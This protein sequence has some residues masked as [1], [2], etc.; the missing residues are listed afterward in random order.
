V[1]EVLAYSDFLVLD[2]RLTVSIQPAVPMLSGYALYWPFRP[3]DRHVIDITLGVLLSEP[4]EFDI[5][6]YVALPRWLAGTRTFRFSSGCVRTDLFGRTD[7]NFLRQLL[8]IQE[9]P[10]GQPA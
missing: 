10:H 3:D 1:P 9:R 5:L 4:S 6:G 7:L 8:D 2:Q